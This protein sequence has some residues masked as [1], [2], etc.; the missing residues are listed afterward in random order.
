[1][2]YGD[3]VTQYI[4]FPFASVTMIPPQIVSN[5]LFPL[6]KQLVE[7]IL[8]YILR[9]FSFPV[10]HE[11][12]PCRRKNGGA[13]ASNP[14]WLI[15]C[16]FTAEFSSPEILLCVSLEKL[17]LSHSPWWLLSWLPVESHISYKL[18]FTRK[19]IF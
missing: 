7:Y 1:M 14:V 16:S 12:F 3:L 5:N 11:A 18:S 2:K 13:G 8:R 17:W 10:E 19:V 9:P 6:R 4:F 15:L